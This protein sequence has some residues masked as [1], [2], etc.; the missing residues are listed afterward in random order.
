MTDLMP[1][2]CEASS[3]MVRGSSMASGKGEFGVFH[4]LGSP[5]GHFLYSGVCFLK[6]YWKGSS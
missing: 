4:V 1:V 2:Q 3:S 6:W 5:G